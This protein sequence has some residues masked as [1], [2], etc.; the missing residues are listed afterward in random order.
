MRLYYDFH[1]HSCLSLC[2]EDDMTPA[3]IA[4]MAA[5][6]GLDTF[7]LSDHQSA[8]NCPACA[9]HAAQHGLLFL[10]ALEL[11]T[12]EEVH[13]LCLFAELRHALDFTEYVGQRLLITPP[14]RKRSLWRQTIM[15]ENDVPVGQEPLWLG[16]PA[17]IGI[18]DTA[19]LVHDAGGLAI[20]AHM[21]R[22]SASI[23]SNLGLYD[24][25]MGFALCELTAGCDE[26]RFMR[27][28]PELRG[29]RFIR[30]GDAHD[31]AAIPDR[32]WTID[33]PER[34]PQAVLRVLSGQG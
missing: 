9:F 2:A 10:P 22:P 12:R 6:A 8:K 13:V 17:D 31:L 3:N 25:A 7:A 27:E 32:Q 24:P 5:L 34:T 33:V 14:A 15:T 19:A 16:S 23:I 11:C 21:D 28:H 18:Y 29:M 26:Q 20:P 30:G 4:G 1:M